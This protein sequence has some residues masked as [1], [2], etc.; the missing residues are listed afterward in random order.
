MA[1]KHEEIEDFPGGVQVKEGTIPG[2]L[3][4]TYIG[5]TAFGILYWILYYA[6]DRSN[7]L[8]AALNAATNH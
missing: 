3:K 6:G 2:F 5:F 1:D 8:V 4:L 7:P